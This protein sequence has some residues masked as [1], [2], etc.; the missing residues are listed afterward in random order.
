MILLKPVHVGLDVDASGGVEPI[1]V[2]VVGVV[3]V[4]ALEVSLNRLIAD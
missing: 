1:G 4:D 3:L 2:E